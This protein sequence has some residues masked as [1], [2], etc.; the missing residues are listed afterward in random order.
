MDNPD[1]GV[2]TF[3][4]GCF[5]LGN[6]RSVAATLVAEGGKVRIGGRRLFRQRV[7]GRN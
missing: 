2:E 5:Q 7:I 4:L 1:T 3:L 6:R